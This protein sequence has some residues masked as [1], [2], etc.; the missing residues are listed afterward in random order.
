MALIYMKLPIIFSLVVAGVAGAAF[1]AGVKYGASEETKSSASK[2]VPAMNSPSPVLG[3]GGK[4]PS[5]GISKDT[6]VQEFY[7]QFGLE[8]GTPLTPDAMTEAMM[9]AIRESDPVRSQL[10]F[11]RLMEEL[12]V[13]NAPVAFAMIRDNISGFD[14]MRY[15]PMLAARWGEV[16]PTTAMKELAKADDRGGRWVQGMA[17]TGWAAK[18]PAAAIAWAGSVETNP[19]EKGMITSQLINGLARSS[20][21]E[22]TKYAAEIKDASE[23]SRAAESIARELI[24]TAGAEKA[25]A[26]VAGITDP[27]MKRGAFQTLSDQLLR[28][29]P[30]KAAE[31]IKKNANEEYAR[32]AVGNLA[33]TLAKKDVQQGLA[34]AG[35]LSGDAQAR[36]YGSV[37]REWVGQNE[38]AGAAEAAKYVESMPAGANKDASSRELAMQAVRE[39]PQTAIAWAGSIQDP[40]KKEEALIDVARRYLRQDPESGAAWLATSGLSEEARKKVRENPGWG[41][42]GGPGGGGPGFGRGPR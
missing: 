1:Y 19:W 26:W 20:P 40:V 35:E 34:L 14:S 32:G 36:A 3:A 17:L 24:R 10:M 15:M 27:D 42:W 8:T 41:G 18:D 6:V 21:E 12:T 2:N 23:R 37:V 16:D 39:D 4:R 5:V 13:E 33:S 11:A 7:K 28:S 31:L 9:T 25:Q 38:G 30:A 22:A 29:D